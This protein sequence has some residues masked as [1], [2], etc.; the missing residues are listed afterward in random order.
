MGSVPVTALSHSTDRT[1]LS[2]YCLPR[3]SNIVESGIVRDEVCVLQHC[4]FCK[5]LY[6]V[7][8]VLDGLILADD[9]IRKHA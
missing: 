4:E 1:S 8:L 6:P 5:H 9:G 3:L 7:L 2:L